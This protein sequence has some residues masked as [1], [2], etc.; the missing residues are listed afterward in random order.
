MRFVLDRLL[1]DGPVRLVGDD[2]VDGHTG[3]HVYGKA[4]HRDAV[5]SPH[6]GTA[7]RYGHKWVV[8]AVPV[9]FPFATRPWALPALIDR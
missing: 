3:P 9:K 7:F 4:R 8:L 5:R 1:P 2:T 6:S